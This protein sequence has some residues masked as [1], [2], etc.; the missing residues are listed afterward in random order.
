M[1]PHTLYV[2]FNYG[3]LVPWSLLVFAPRWRW[4]RRLVHGAL[5]PLV[6]CAAHA[7]LIVA[8]Y[9]TA[10]VPDGASGATLA[11][12]MRMFDAPWLALVCWIHY[13]AFDLFVGA[14]MARD[15]ARHELPHLAVA[16]CLV[17][18]LFFGPA[19][20]LVYFVVR[21]V[22]RRRTSFEEST[23]KLAELPAIAAG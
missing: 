1:N 10:N 18:T 21:Y 9:A 2:Y 19:G 4:T 14:W 11:S 3:I 22:L 13:L 6:L 8:L 7:S 17:V 16:P 23:S 20:F 5:V 12:V 15:G